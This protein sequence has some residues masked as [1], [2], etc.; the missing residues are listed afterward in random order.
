MRRDAY[1]IITF[2]SSA[3]VTIS[4][5]TSSDP[6]QLLDLILSN[7]NYYGGTNF[8]RAIETIQTQLENTWS[9]ERSPVVIFLSDGECAISD[10]TVYDLC[11]SAIRLGRPLALYTVSFGRESSSS[12][13]RRIATVAGEVYESAPPDPLAPVGVNPC[14]YTSALS[15]VQLANTF[16]NIAESLKNPRAALSRI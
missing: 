8:T 6:D 1:S 15:T 5:D 7:A 12:S 13:L 16:M 2:E 4:N 14:T 11:R 10:S 9:T 3:S